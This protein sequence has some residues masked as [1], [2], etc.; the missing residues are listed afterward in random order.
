MKGGGNFSHRLFHLEDEMVWYMKEEAEG[1]LVKWQTAFDGGLAILMRRGLV[2]LKGGKFVECATE[3][4]LRGSVGLQLYDAE[5]GVM[6]LHPSYV[7]PAKILSSD[8]QES[9]Q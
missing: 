2:D 7:W 6:I 5:H 4:L 3:D 8:T 9:D 1:T